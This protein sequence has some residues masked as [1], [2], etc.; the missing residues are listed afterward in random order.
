MSTI[1][2]LVERFTTPLQSAKANTDVI[3]L[4]FS[5]MM[6]YAVQY[7]ALSTL[8][9]H[10]VWWRLFHAPNH[11]EWSNVL[12][13]AELVFSLPASNGKLERIFS[14]LGT[15]KVDTRSRLTNESLDDQ[16]VVKCDKIPLANFDPNPSIDLWWSAKNRRPSQK[17]RKQYNVRRS[18]HTLASQQ[19]PDSETNS[20][21]ESEP[22]IMLDCWDAIMNSETGVDD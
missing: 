14:T 10:A 16:L 11:A 17:K 7:I 18:K 21:S 5:C 13:L 15:I 8:D 20:G 2:S 9:Y 1:G 4:E 19:E 6:E 22:E 3:Q 12:I